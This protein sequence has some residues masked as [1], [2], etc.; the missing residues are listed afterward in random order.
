MEKFIEIHELVKKNPKLQIM[1]KL[2]LKTSE[3]YAQRSPI[4]FTNSV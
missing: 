4:E 1:K 3:K 2:L